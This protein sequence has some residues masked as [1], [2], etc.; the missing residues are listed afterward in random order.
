MTSMKK[1]L[2]L[3]VLCLAAFSA[4]AQDYNWAIGARGGGS[5]SGVTFKHILSD[6]NAL[7][8]DVNFQYGRDRMAH[9]TVFSLMYEWNR[10]I[11][12]DGFLFYYGLGAHVGAATMTKE[13]SNNY[14]AIVLG[15]LAVTGIEYKPY[16]IPIAFSL[17]YRPFLNVLPQPR[18]FFANVG[19]G[20]KYCF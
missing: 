20:I 15:A 3:L 13:G 7:E 2:I 1:T 10:P 9:S 4:Q 19:L 16:S 6:Y 11:I 12:S 14:G 17:D 8:M 5:E 18:F